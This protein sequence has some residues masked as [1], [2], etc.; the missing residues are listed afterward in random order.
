VVTGLGERESFRPDDFLAYYRRL[1]QRF[2]DATENRRP[3]YP[4]PVD[5]CGLCDF[6]SLCKERWAA[7]DHL[8]LVAGVS[9]LQVERLQAAGIMT[10]EALADAAPDTR[11]RACGPPL[12]TGST[13]RRG[14][15]STTGAPASTGSSTSPRSPATASR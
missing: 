13:T 5:F 9:R 11:C 14:S 6:L 7:D 1:R 4:Y 15:S 2:L 3:T 8:T 10:L 12:S